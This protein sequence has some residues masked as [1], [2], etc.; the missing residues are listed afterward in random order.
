MHKIYNNT[1]SHSKMFYVFNVVLYKLFL[2]LKGF[3]PLNLE[4]KHCIMLSN[5]D[6]QRDNKKENRCENWNISLA[7]QLLQKL[8][9]MSQHLLTSI[10]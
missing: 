9:R 8:Y 1:R 2:I 4:Y 10:Y 3:F 5:T 7:H 6:E